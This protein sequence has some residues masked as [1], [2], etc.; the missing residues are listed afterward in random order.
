MTFKAAS[1]NLFTGKN[2]CKAASVTAKT[3]WGAL[4]VY[5]ISKG[6]ELASV[7]G[8]ATSALYMI[9]KTHNLRYEQ[10]INL[11]K[12]D[13]LIFAFSSEDEDGNPIKSLTLSANME[14]KWCVTK[15]VT[16]FALST[17]LFLSTHVQINPDS[18]QQQVLNEILNGKEKASFSHTIYV[19]EETKWAIKKDEVTIHAKKIADQ[20]SHMTVAV[21][22]NQGDKIVE[23]IRFPNKPPVAISYTPKEYDA[24]RK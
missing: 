11:R 4:G 21:T 7:Y 23:L 17:M 16:P 5:S 20:P 15:Y 6:P 24:L 22:G 9:K 8:I 3:A 2:M 19:P 13:K 10:D 18:A 14:E 1:K 12:G